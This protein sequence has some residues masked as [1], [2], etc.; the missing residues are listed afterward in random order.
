MGDFSAKIVSGW[1]PWTPL[2][3]RPS[4]PHLIPKSSIQATKVE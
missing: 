1:N 4:P 2:A 3:N